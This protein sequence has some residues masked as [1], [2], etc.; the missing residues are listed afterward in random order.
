MRY[1]YLVKNGL[2]YSLL[3]LFQASLTI[4]NAKADRRCP[5]PRPVAVGDTKLA[6]SPVTFSN[7]APEIQ[8]AVLDTV[9]KDYGITLIARYE[10][11]NVASADYLVFYDNRMTAQVEAD[12]K[13]RLSIINSN[14]HP[15]G[16][17]TQAR[18]IAVVSSISPTEPADVRSDD[19]MIYRSASGTL[20]AK[21]INYYQD[22]CWEDL[23]SW[24]SNQALGKAIHFYTSDG[25]NYPVN[26][27]YPADIETFD[28][29][30]GW[31]IDQGFQDCKNYPEGKTPC[32]HLGQDWNDIDGLNSDL[33]HPVFAVSRGEVI[34]A[35]DAGPGWNGIVVL[36]HR[37]PNGEEIFSLYGHLNIDPKAIRNGIAGNGKTNGDGSRIRTV[38]EVLRQSSPENLV[39]VEKG[40]LI[41]YIGPGPLGVASH[42]HFEIIADSSIAYDKS[43]WVGYRTLNGNRQQWHDPAV[44]IPAN[45]S[46]WS[47]FPIGYN[48]YHDLISPTF[49][50][51]YQDNGGQV[52]LGETIGIT[53]TDIQSA[54]GESLGYQAFENGE[55]YYHSP[56]SRS[57]LA[58]KASGILNPFLA[59]FRILA[60][61]RMPMQLPY[62]W[63]YSPI[64]ISNSGLGFP[65][66]DTSVNP[67]ISYFGTK[68]KFQNFENG[69]LELHQTGLYTG[70]VFE[71]KGAIFSRWSDKSLRY[72][73]GTLGLPIDD[74]KNAPKSKI[75][76]YGG[77]FSFFEGGA[78]YWIREENKTYVIG[79]NQNLGIYSGIGKLIADSYQAEG[80][81]GGKL[82]FPKSDDHLSQNG[83]RCDF[84]GGYILWTPTTGM[85][86]FTY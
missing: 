50:K 27:R 21:T 18:I 14:R 66:S 42:L 2:F 39:E 80:G 48:S 37:P 73:S 59:K 32:S 5:L 77:R 53:F 22:A 23:I 3:L 1:R 10:L 36:R 84:E 4:K 70:E 82:G 38:A 78:I 30:A 68:F 49:E 56:V 75:S 11:P 12:F 13:S 54:D 24:D 71:I 6:W 64:D 31:R 85:Q 51:F 43:Q 29:S 28:V 16:R 47:K 86:I 65:I 40:Q 83:I 69:A 25:F 67:E 19:L 60:P 55:V 20:Y 63:G 9:P 61:A 76:G 34:F 44:F 41:G 35:D 45:R 46:Y 57:N 52:M 81:S 72:A 17:D 7:L 74:E 33:G 26:P 8:R 15:R 62:L 58:D 79:M